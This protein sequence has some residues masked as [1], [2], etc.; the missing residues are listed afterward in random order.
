MPSQST[1]RTPTFC[2][3]AQQKG[4][5]GRLWT[6]DR[7]GRRSLIFN[8][9]ATCR[10]EA[11]SLFPEQ[12]YQLALWQLIRRTRKSYMQAQVIQIALAAFLGPTWEY[13]VR[14]MAETHGRL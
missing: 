9:F 6:A 2:T 11:G 10:L 5:S 7:A 8:S 14:E 13:F 12:P 1:Q 3:L 4:E